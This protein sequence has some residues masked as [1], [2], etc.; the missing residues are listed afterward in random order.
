MRT[1]RIGQNSS[2]YY[3]YEKTVDHELLYKALGEYKLSQKA[4]LAKK[5]LDYFIK[6]QT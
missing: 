4:T 6:Q 2:K 3:G 1:S 5:N